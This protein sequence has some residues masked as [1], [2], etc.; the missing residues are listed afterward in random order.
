MFFKDDVEWSL[1]GLMKVLVEADKLWNEHGQTLVITSLMEGNHSEDSKHYYGKAV[2][3]RTRY[4][5]TIERFKVANKLEERL[6]KAYF[7]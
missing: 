5:S 7:V 6:G 4:F 1:Q 3:L 2:D